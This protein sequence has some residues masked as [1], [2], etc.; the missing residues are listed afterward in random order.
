MIGGETD[1]PVPGMET[2]KP[3]KSV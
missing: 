1:H 3:V 2:V